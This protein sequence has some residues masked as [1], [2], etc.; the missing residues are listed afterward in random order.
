MIT[1]DCP[2]CDGSATT[3]EHLTTLTCEGCD[4]TVDVAADTLVELGVAA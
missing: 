3:D 2:L 1:I 4:I